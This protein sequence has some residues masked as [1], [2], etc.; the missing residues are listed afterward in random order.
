MFD[1][2]NFDFE[3]EYLL[4]MFLD[5]DYTPFAVEPRGGLAWK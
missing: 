5:R 4:K 1:P 2:Q 3:I